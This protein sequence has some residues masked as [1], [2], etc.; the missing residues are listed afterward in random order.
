MKRTALLMLLALICLS[1][2]RELE[3]NYHPFCEISVKVD[4]SL[5]DESPSGMSV[6]L[7]PEDGK[8]P[9]VLL[10]NQ[11]DETRVSVREG[12]Y[13]VLVINQSP[14][15][16][17]TIRF[18]GMNRFETA[19]ATAAPQSYDWIDNAEGRTDDEPTVC[20]PEPLAVAVHHRLV[21]TAEMVAEY[22]AAVKATARDLRAAAFLE[23]QPQPVISTA[24]VQVR[25]NGIQNI[26]SVRGYFSGMSAGCL[27]AER[28][29]L[30]STVSH[31]L[32]DWEI[33][34]DDNDYTKGEIQTRFTTFGCYDR[35]G[36]ATEDR[37]LSRADAFSNQLYLDLL[38]VDNATIVSTSFWVGDRIEMQQEALSIRLEVGTDTGTD[39]PS[40]DDPNL[41]LPLPDVKPENGT[42][43]GFDATVEDWGEEIEI[44]IDV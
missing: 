27:L 11:V 34:H 20:H 6:Y 13:N 21:I 35:E 44:D 26:R 16:F 2:R 32:T 9:T 38:L 28:R 8:E 43:S 17:G 29:Y 4:W 42:S 22:Q 31:I 15:E 10:T 7:Y 3:Y 41:P 12:V 36:D 37:S 18:S 40:G 19:C 24:T 1:C 30:K 25:V 33:L 23:L 39:T 14:S 5:M